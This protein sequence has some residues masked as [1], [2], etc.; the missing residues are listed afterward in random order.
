MISCGAMWTTG[1]LS[2]TRGNFDALFATPVTAQHIRVTVQDFETWPSMRAGLLV[3]L[4]KEEKE[5]REAKEAE[6]WKEALNTMLAPS[7]DWKWPT[8]HG[9]DCKDYHPR[10][11]GGKEVVGGYARGYYL[12]ASAWWWCGK[13]VGGDYE[14]SKINW[15]MRATLRAPATHS[16]LKRIWCERCRLRRLHLHV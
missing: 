7:M 12:L 6:E 1:Q 14:Q 4:T 8:A 5:A 3:H 10:I 2:R 9:V 11:G 16:T 15:Q 13:E